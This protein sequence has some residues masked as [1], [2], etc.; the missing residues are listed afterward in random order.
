MVKNI[1]VFTLIFSSLLI[2]SNTKE[3]ENQRKAKV[4]QQIQKEIQREKKYAKERTFY[5]NKNYDFKGA[6]VNQDSLKSIPDLEPEDDFD[7]DS[8]YD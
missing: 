5:Q 2:A 8:V 1:L 7:M 4:D 3:S 6:E